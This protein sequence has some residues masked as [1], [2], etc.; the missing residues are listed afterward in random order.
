[1][2]PETSVS[3]VQQNQ[4]RS[5]SHTEMADTSWETYRSF[6][7]ELF[8]AHLNLPCRKPAVKVSHTKC[9]HHCVIRTW[10][11]HW[12]QKNSTDLSMGH[13]A[14][15]RVALDFCSNSSLVTP[16]STGCT[17]ASPTLPLSPSQGTP[18]GV[19][20][21]LARLHDHLVPPLPFSLPQPS[22]F[23]LSVCSS[24]Y[25]WDSLLASP[26]GDSFG[27]FKTANYKLLE[28]KSWSSSFLYS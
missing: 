27:A 18:G 1:M 12:Y 15:P 9:H 26:L 22:S 20:A 6:L 13:Q 4:G 16:W 19:S 25:H 7:L 2:C 5:D 28:V 23:M 17:L 24:R 10:T 21:H 11:P 3:L 14:L 8:P